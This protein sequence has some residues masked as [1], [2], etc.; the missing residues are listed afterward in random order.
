MSPKFTNLKGESRVLQGNLQQISASPILCRRFER[1]KINE[2]ILQEPRTI[3]EKIAGLKPQQGNVRYSKS[4]IR[5]RTCI[6]CNNRVNCVLIPELCSVD[7]DQ[8]ILSAETEDLKRLVICPAYLSGDIRDCSPQ[9]LSNIA[10]YCTESRL[11]LI[12]R[13]D[14]NAHYTALGSTNINPSSKN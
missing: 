14:A 11:Q 1:D 4:A 8:A 9:K 12:V 5:R 2:A 7:F 13:C 10:A 6:I 3:R